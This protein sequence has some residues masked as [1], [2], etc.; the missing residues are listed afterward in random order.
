MKF[1]VAEENARAYMETTNAPPTQAK[2]LEEWYAQFECME[3]E[4]VK[5]VYE[6]SFRPSWSG[7]QQPYDGPL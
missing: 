2:L 3:A 6:G 1:L 4:D 7:I 5:T